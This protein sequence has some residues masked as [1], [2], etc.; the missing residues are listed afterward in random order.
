MINDTWGT[1]LG[2]DEKKDTPKASKFS[3]T[4][5]KSNLGL[6][7]HFKESIPLQYN[8]NVNALALTKTFKTLRDNGVSYQTIHMMIDRFFYEINE[9]PI[10]KETELWANFIGRRENLLKWAT[11]NQPDNDVSEW[12][13]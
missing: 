11:L 13:A 4:A 9:K 10:N 3:S 1:P 2:A 12:K 7:Y 5:I 6:I 8:G